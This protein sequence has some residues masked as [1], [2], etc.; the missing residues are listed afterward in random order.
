MAKNLSLSQKNQTMNEDQHFKDLLKNYAS[1]T[2]QRE[3]LIEQL[4]PIVMQYYGYRHLYFSPEAENFVTAQFMEALSPNEREILELVSK[5]KGTRNQSPE[6]KHLS[7]RA[8]SIIKKLKRWYIRLGHDIYPMDMNSIGVV[9]GGHV[10]GED[11]ESV[12]TE[13]EVMRSENKTIAGKKAKKIEESDEDEDEEE[14]EED[15]DEEVED[16]VDDSSEY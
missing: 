12:A 16:Q 9:G 3:A 10:V 6:Q 2:E 11:D 5:H 1:L 7:K 13:T 4:H 8:Q 15:E 14:F